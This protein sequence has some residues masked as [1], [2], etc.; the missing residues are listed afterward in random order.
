MAEDGNR[1]GVWRKRILGGVAV[2]ALGLLGIHFM[3]DCHPPGTLID[4]PMGAV[5]FDPLRNDPVKDPPAPPERTAI[6]KDFKVGS[7]VSGWTIAA[8]TL[9]T[10]DDMAGALTVLLVNGQKSFAVWIMPREKAKLASP[11][12]TS[13][14][15]FHTGLLTGTAKSETTA[16]VEALVKQVRSY[17]GSP[18]P[19]N[20]V[21]A[22]PPQSAAP[23]ASAP[24]A[25]SASAAPGR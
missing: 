16:P 4:T 6:L 12:G 15:T 23:A 8:L 20:A 5:S 2:G 9:S 1:S 22:C 11:H 19:P 14:F 7:S 21:S 18:E 25:G 10:K 3:D 13:G 17:E 24:P